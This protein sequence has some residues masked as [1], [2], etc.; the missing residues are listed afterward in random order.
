MPAAEASHPGGHGT[1]SG[2]ERPRA[3]S[4]NL[5]NQKGHRSMSRNP[6]HRVVL[7]VLALLLVTIVA[8]ACGPEPTPTPKPTVPAVPSLPTQAPAKPTTPPTAA[9]AVPTAAPTAAPA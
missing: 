4:G 2:S 9:P 6:I 3:T 8:S 1:G 5:T 7:I